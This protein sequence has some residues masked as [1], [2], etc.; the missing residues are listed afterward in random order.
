MRRLI[1]GF[2]GRTY[3]IV[4][5]LMPR[6]K[7][8][9]KIQNSSYLIFR[10]LV[11]VLPRRLIHVYIHVNWRYLLRVKV[12]YWHKGLECS[13]SEGPLVKQ[14]KCMGIWTVLDQ[15]YALLTSF[16]NSEESEQ[17]AQC[18]ARADHGSAHLHW[19]LHPFWQSMAELLSNDVTCLVAYEEETGRLSYKNHTI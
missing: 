1:W 2:V 14:D 9:E 17:F 6:H 3:H 4:G 10:Q 11:I 12:P 16:S 5:N 15:D 13:Y 8:P 18:G 7:Y 19:Q